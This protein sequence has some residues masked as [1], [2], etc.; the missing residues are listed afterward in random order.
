MAGSFPTFTGTQP[1]YTREGPLYTVKVDQGASGFEVRTVMGESHGARYRYKV[2]IILRNELGEVTDFID[3]VDAQ[4]GS[5]DSFTMDDPIDG[6][7]RGVRFEG[8][9]SLTQHQGVDGW[10]K[11]TMN[12]VSVIT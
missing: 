1:T 9:P 3:H 5:G 6:V 4:Y 7:N 10:W 8:P 2:E 11:A 12:L